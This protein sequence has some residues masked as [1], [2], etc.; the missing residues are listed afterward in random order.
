MTTPDPTA[1]VTVQRKVVTSFKRHL[2]LG[3]YNN[4]EL[5][6]SIED[7]VDLDADTE[8]IVSKLRDL[9][10]TVKATLISELGLEFD[11]ADDGVI[12]EVLRHEF[13]Q[14]TQVVPT[15]QGSTEMSGRTTTN[16]SPTPPHDPDSLDWK[17]SADKP[18]LDENRAWAAQLYLSDPDSFYDNRDSKT[19]NSQ[20]DFRHKATKISIW[21]SDVAKVKRG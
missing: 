14:Q 1:P 2:N 10:S 16:V 11:V 21:E 20:P 17:N 15:S 4:A 9:A 12:L 6:M 19:K 5:F 8:T 7:Y 18:K 13:G 3:D